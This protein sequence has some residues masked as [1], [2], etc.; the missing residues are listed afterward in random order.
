MERM[1][2]PASN[3]SLALN[4]LP[5]PTQPGPL[6]FPF[7]D[8]A[9]GLAAIFVF[10]R[11]A[12]VF[13]PPQL[14]HALDHPWEFV[15]DVFS[16]KVDWPTIIA[17]IV[18]Y[19]GRFCWLALPIFFVVSGFCIHLSYAQSSPPR[20]KKFFIRRFFRIYP[21][22]LFALLIF[23]TV[24]PESRLP[25]TKLTHWAMLGAHIFNFH[26]LFET[27]IYAVN[28]S[29]WTIGVEVQMYLLFPLLLL[30]ARR[31]S[32]GRLLFALLLVEV[33]LHCFSAFYWYGPD[34]FPPAWLRA[35]PFFF[36]FSWTLGA[37][38]AD[39]FL[40]GKPLP[41][42]KIHPLVWVVPGILISQYPAHEF[43]FTFFSLAIVSVIWRCL[44]QASVE[45]PK[46]YLGRFLRR[47]GVYS[48]SIY[49]IHG[50]ILIFLMSLVEAWF[51]G[52]RTDPFLVLGAALSCWLVIFPLGALMYRWVEK[53]GM[54]LGKRVLRSGSKPETSQLT[55]AVS[56]S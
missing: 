30:F 48:Y 23:A 14:D 45:E 6:H 40:S 32:Y 16:G 18:N 9:R 11:H 31:F 15:S 34:R 38:T 26:N 52:I 46:S 25:F 49:L 50:P 33:S 12:Q 17:F 39:A 29:Y 35:S 28:A 3:R 10:I 8:D 5:V 37:A 20:L 24:F 27:S 2:S 56:A 44:T 51:P 47:T 54:A 55:T 41:F 1:E 36:C 7:V 53:P 42:L 22:Y 19:P 43:G 13:L 21:A 4:Q